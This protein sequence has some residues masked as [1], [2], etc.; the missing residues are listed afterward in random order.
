MPG[1]LEGRRQRG[2]GVALLQGMAAWRVL[3]LC[4]VISGAQGVSCCANEQLAAVALVL[5]AEAY[6]E[7]TRHLQKHGIQVA[8]MRSAATA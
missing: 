4:A 2:E 1:H 8:G 5:L 3:L 7:R 6:A